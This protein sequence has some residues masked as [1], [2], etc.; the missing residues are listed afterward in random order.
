MKKI[1]SFFTPLSI[2]ALLMASACCEKAIPMNNCV[3]KTANPDCIC[4]LIYKPVCGCNGKTY[5]NECV[6]RCHNITQ[7]KEGEC[8]K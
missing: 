7:F 3:E 6:A 4:T 1:I 8:P 2:A 5:G